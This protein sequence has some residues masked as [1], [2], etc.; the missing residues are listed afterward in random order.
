MCCFEQQPEIRLRLL[1]GTPKFAIMKL[2]LS[3]TICVMKKI[4]PM[5]PCFDMASPEILYLYVT[6]EKYWTK[7][8]EKRKNL[9]GQQLSADQSI[10]SNWRSPVANFVHAQVS[11]N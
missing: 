8:T 2:F 3:T 4:K 11:F 9:D 10:P 6:C 7:G 5:S 1:Q